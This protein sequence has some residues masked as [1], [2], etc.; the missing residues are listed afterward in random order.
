MTGGEIGER[1][2]PALSAL[3]ETLRDDYVDDCRKGVERWNRTLAGVGAELR[4]PHAGFNRRVGAFSGVAIAP[5]GCV[6]AEQAW[7]AQAY[8]W[9]PSDDDATFVASLM[10][11]AHEPGKMAGWIAAPSSGIHA[12][13]LDFDYVKL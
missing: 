5:D 9:L 13:P 6:L 10:Q 3:N 4:L 7:Q 11:P 12:R 1:E 2:V 8:E